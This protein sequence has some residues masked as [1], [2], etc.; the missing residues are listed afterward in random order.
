LVAHSTYRGIESSSKPMKSVTRLS[1]SART[2]IPAI[3]AR[4]RE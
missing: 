3:E 1:A 4:R 2:T